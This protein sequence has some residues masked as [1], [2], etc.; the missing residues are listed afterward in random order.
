MNAAKTIEE[1]IQAVCVASPLYRGYRIRR[2]LAGYAVLALVCAVIYLCWH[3]WGEIVGGLWALVSRKSASWSAAP[4]AQWFL[5]LILCLFAAV[6]VYEALADRK[7]WPAVRDGKATDD[8]LVAIVQN[9]HIQQSAKASLASEIEQ[10]GYVSAAALGE[11][12]ARADR[13]AVVKKRQAE[14]QRARFELGP[15]AT[16]MLNYRQ[17]DEQAGGD[18]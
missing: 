10:H 8:L 16:A 5:W 12:A 1:T 6:I 13:E 2:A 14:I 15:G 3:H 9:P 7:N 18:A 17:S 4:A 11:V